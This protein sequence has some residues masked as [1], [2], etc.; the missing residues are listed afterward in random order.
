ML[1]V[2]WED[3][4][5]KCTILGKGEGKTWLSSFVYVM[6]QTMATEFQFY[7]NGNYVLG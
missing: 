1:E 3:F 7:N 6:L 4:G 2:K 5:I